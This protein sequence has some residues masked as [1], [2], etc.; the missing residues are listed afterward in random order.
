MEGL[1]AQSGLPL[2]IQTLFQNPTAIAHEEKELS[3]SSSSS[4]VDV[5]IDMGTDSLENL[6][7]ELLRQVLL[8]PGKVEAQ[9][10]TLE[11]G[12]ALAEIMG[13]LKLVRSF[14]LFPFFA[15]F[16]PFLLCVFA[17]HLIVMFF[18]LPSIPGQQNA[19]QNC[20]LGTGHL[21]IGR[22]HHPSRRP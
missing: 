4:D 21:R 16:P 10:E 22:A 18:S 15:F 11:A 1:D 3:S 8:L 9:L 17:I 2:S 14:F 12:N 7:T 19:Y 20:T 13:V 5:D 6:N